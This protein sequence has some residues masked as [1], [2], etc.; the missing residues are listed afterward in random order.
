MAA[1]LTRTARVM[2]KL[3]NVRTI[4]VAIVMTG[5][6]LGAA[7][8][9]AAAEADGAVNVVAADADTTIVSYNVDEVGVFSATGCHGTTCIY[10]NGKGLKVEY[11]TVTNKKGKYNGYGNISSTY[12]GA[13]LISPYVLRKG[14]SWRFDYKRIMRNGNKICGSIAGRD[15]AC[16]KIKK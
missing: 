10:V 11:A 15:V 3:N 8:A 4:A 1:R 14:D 6:A 2:E 12:D 13:T 7:A 9:P 16:V 5:A